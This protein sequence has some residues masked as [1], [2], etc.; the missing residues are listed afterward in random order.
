VLFADIDGGDDGV[1]YAAGM[2]TAAVYP[3]PH[4][5]VL[6]RPHIA[7]R[8][9]GGVHA[10][11]LLDAPVSLPA[12]EDRLYYK[13]TLR[14]FV[15]AIGGV[16]PGAH[17]D[18]SCCDPARILRVPG[19]FNYKQDVPRPVEILW[20]ELTRP[21]YTFAE[22]DSMLPREPRPSG[23]PVQSRSEP[24]DSI[25]CIHPALRAGLDRWAAKGYPEGN[26]HHDLT[27]AAAWLI[28]D[29]K[30]DAE[31]ALGFLRAKATSSPGR[32]TITD[33]ELEKMITWAPR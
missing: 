15:Q 4:I 32:R 28:H 6:P 26:R 7:V 8:S 1:A 5:P 21:R 9:G 29:V 16:S 3:Q 33:T 12:D 19:T 27:G 22:W 14:R 17:A 31:D 11:W 23:L 18:P 2:L 25:G 24:Y 20:D 30:I 13:K 10:Y